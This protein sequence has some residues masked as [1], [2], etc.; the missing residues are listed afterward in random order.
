MHELQ[1]KIY[2]FIKLE[3]SNGFVFGANEW[4]GQIRC[5]EESRMRERVGEMRSPD[6][7]AMR[8]ATE[9]RSD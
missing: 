9:H 4:T 2:T 6:A 7:Y 5:C 8:C 1:R 3:I